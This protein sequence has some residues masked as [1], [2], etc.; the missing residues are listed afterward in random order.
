[1]RIKGE[2]IDDCNVMDPLNLH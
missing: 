1:L 2:A